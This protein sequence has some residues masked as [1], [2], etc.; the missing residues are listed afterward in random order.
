MSY[1]IIKQMQTKAG[2]RL[3]VLMNDGYGEILVIEDENKAMEFISVLNSNTDSG[4]KYS[5]LAVPK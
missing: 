5:I 1:R 4:C 3:N 2:Q